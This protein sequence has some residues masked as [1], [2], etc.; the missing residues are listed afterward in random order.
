MRLTL[1]FDS[2]SQ[3]GL[4]VLLV[5]GSF[6]DSVLFFFLWLYFDS[7]LRICGSVSEAKWLLVSTAIPPSF[8]YTLRVV[9]V[10]T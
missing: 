10:R 5:T 8:R 7:L 1:P 6:N 2:A 9:A 3:H 4:L